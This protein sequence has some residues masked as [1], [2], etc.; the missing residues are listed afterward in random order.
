MLIGAVTVVMDK[1][2]LLTEQQQLVQAAALV[3]NMLKM[4]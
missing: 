3:V 1:V 2:L 4:S